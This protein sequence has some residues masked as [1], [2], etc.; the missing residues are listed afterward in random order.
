MFQSFGRDFTTSKASGKCGARC[1][2]F[3]PGYSLNYAERGPNLELESSQCYGQAFSSSIGACAMTTKFLDN[4]ICTFK[5]L[6]SWR[7]PRKQAFLGDYPLCPQGP[8]PPK[9]KFYFYCRLAFS[10]SIKISEAGVQP[11]PAQ[12]NGRMPRLHPHVKC[13]PYTGIRTRK[14]LQDLPLR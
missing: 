13:P 10:S 5:I 7:F 2:M 14:H 3:S 4:K 6:L 9:R 11:R 12:P 1:C 8:P